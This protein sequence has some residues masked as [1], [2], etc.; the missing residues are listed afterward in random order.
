KSYTSTHISMPTTDI[1]IF[2]QCIL[3]FIL[4]LNNNVIYYTKHK[5]FSV[6]PLK[7]VMDC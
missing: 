1:T 7:F 5:L 6:F 3:K 4:N 2:F